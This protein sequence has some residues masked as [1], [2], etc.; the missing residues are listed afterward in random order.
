M[1]DSIKNGFLSYTDGVVP[2]PEKIENISSIIPVNFR[3]ITFIEFNES[4]KTKIN[5]YNF[6]G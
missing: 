2:T 5:R 3:F 6:H 4:N 1:A